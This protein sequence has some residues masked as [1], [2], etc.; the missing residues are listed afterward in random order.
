MRHQN[1]VLF[2]FE[3]L[4]NM[5]LNKFLKILIKLIKEPKIYYYYVIIN[6]KSPKIKIK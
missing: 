4:D 1:L 2:Y 3:F 6:Y 5:Y